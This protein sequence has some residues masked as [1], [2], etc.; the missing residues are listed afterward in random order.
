MPVSEGKRHIVDPVIK[1]TNDVIFDNV[2]R[3]P[4]NQSKG[5]ISFSEYYWLSVGTIVSKITNKH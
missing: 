4:V 1:E 2:I 5:C 3:S